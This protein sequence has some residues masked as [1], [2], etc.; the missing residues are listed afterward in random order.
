MPTVSVTGI[1]C[2]TLYSLR[3]GDEMPSF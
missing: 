2:P 3:E 1:F